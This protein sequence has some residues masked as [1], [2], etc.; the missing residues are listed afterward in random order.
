MICRTG[1]HLVL[2]LGLVTRLQV[3]PGREMLDD[4]KNA[5]RYLAGY[6]LKLNLKEYDTVSRSRVVS[7]VG[8]ISYTH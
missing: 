7:D 2:S 4:V 5:D 8:G 1:D 3:P 6:S